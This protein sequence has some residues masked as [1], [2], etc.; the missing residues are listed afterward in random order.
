MQKILGLIYTRFDKVYSIHKRFDCFLGPRQHKWA[1]FNAK[2]SGYVTPFF[3]TKIIV[4][5]IIV[6]KIVIARARPTARKFRKKSKIRHLRI[7]S[8]LASRCSMIVK[9]LSQKDFILNVRKHHQTCKGSSTKN[10]R[11]NIGFS[12]HPLSGWIRIS[13]TF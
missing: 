3:N 8:K 4:L 13:K 2:G 5:K 11:Q 12:N 6:L 1:V 9:M 10:V 7:N